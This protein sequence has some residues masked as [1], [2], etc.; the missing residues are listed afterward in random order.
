MIICG[1]CGIKCTELHGNLTQPQRLQALDEFRLGRVDVLLASDL[2]CRGLDIEAVQTVINFEMPSNLD[3]YVHRIGRTARAGRGGRSCTLI[4]EGRR[5]LMKDLI[6]NADASKKQRSGDA[7]ALAPKEVGT[8]VIRSRTIPP[9]VVTHFVEKIQSLEPHID[10]VLQAEAVAK[11]DRLAEMEAVRA[12]NIIEHSDEI[13]SRPQREWFASKKEKELTKQ[14]TAERQ[15]LAEEKAG[16]G[17]HRMTRKKRRAREAL[18]AVNAPPDTSSNRDD[19]DED[20]PPAARHEQPPKV[21]IKVE[22]RKKKKS[23]AAKEHEAAGRSVHDLDEAQR[24]AQKKRK[25]GSSSSSSHAAGDG[26][27]FAEDRMNYASKKKSKDGSSSKSSG[28]SAVAK[29][30]YQFQGYDPDRKLGKKRGNKA[31]KSK[32]KYKRRK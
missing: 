5:H 15:K 18:K 14:T 2:A 22:A 19:A 4:G 8:G 6:R 12:Q 30:G 21:N 1:L 13:Q 20:G 28:D 11:M 25:A 9:A 29:S 17:T 7:A 23:E 3:T 24:A 32:S 26:S 10:E 16:T 31:F 27:L